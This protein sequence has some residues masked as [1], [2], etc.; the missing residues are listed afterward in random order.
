MFVTGLIFWLQ[1]SCISIER[2]FANARMPLMVLKIVRFEF[3]DARIAV[4][5]AVLVL[6]PE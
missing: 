5:G 6:V 3:H 1:G 2:L 4:T